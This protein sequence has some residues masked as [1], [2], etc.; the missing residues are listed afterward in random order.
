MTAR[1]LYKVKITYEVMVVAEDKD[2]AYFVTKKNVRDMDE[3]FSD[4]EVVETIESVDQLPADW[5]GALPYGDNPY[6]LFCD[7][8]LKLRKGYHLF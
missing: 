3:P 5:I 4:I 1:N 2:D 8:I 6:E 7:Q